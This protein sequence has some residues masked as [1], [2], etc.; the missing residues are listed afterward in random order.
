MRSSTRSSSSP[1]WSASSIKRLR[2]DSSGMLLRLAFSIAIQVRST[3]FS[4]TSPRSR[5]PAFRQ[6][7]FATFDGFHAGK[8]VVFVSHDLGT[9]QRYCNRGPAHPQRSRRGERPCPTRSSSSTSRPLP[10]TK[11]RTL[12]R[13]SELEQALAEQE[14]AWE[15]RP[16]VRRLYLEWFEA[17]RARLADTRG[18]TGQAVPG[19]ARLREVVPDIVLTDV[20]PTRWTQH[21]ADAEHLPWDDGAVGNLRARRRVPPPAAARN[22][23]RRSGACT[24]A[25]RATW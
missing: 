18:T 11:S 5:R 19:I 4:S 12:H 21:V 10:P 6:K 22:L 7:C 1:S 20:E 16:L 17:I 13:I 14:R 25:R 15:S 24:R 8:T 9:V 3:S 2:L 23:S